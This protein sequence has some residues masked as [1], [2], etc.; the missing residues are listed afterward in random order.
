MIQ[1]IHHI[2]HIQTWNMTSNQASPSPG[3]LLCFQSSIHLVFSGALF[4][5]T[6]HRL[7]TTSF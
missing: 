1:I 4:A 7:Y 6:E 3:T 2:Q 5:G